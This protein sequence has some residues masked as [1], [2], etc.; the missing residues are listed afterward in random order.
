[1]PIPKPYGNESQD[2]YMKRCMSDSTMRAEYSTNQRTAVCMATFKGKGENMVEEA[3]ENQETDEQDISEEEST[4][5]KYL[6]SDFEIKMPDEDEEDE[7]YK[8]TFSGYASIFGNKDLGN[9][10]VVRGAFKDSLRK[11]RAKNIKFLYMHK[12]DEPIGVFTK[13]DEDDRGLQV[14]GRLALGTQRGKEVYELMKM[15]AIDGLS[16]G[17]KVDAKGY[18]YDDRSRRRKLKEVDLM[19]ISAVTFPMNPKAR[20]RA[21]KGTEMTIR[22]WEKTLREVADLSIS[23]SKMAAKAVTKALNQREVDDESQQLINS[24]NNLTKTIKGD[25]DV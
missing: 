10:V 23:E 16:I 25:T 19:E 15:G 13:I 9:D 12:T 24:I 1:M 17:Y 2:E 7:R 22:E 8:G 18:S 3:T 11:K 20:I 4:Q 6:Y 14:E 21:V 5:T